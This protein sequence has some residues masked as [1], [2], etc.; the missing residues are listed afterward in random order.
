[1]LKVNEAFLERFFTLTAEEQLQ[2]NP[3]TVVRRPL[4]HRIVVDS[5][6]GVCVAREQ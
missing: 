6:L 2:G 4:V 1:M 5:D 3:N